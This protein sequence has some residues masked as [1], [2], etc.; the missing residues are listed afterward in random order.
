M[1]G[2]KKDKVEQPQE[3]VEDT[4]VPE[5]QHYKDME[6]RLEKTIDSRFERFEKA[7]EKFFTAASVTSPSPQKRKATKRPAPPA[8]NNH[9]TRNKALRSK[10]NPVSHTDPEVLIDN[11]DENNIQEFESPA[12]PGTSQKATRQ[13]SRRAGSRVTTDVNKDGG[14]HVPAASASLNPA[15]AKLDMNNWLLQQGTFAAAQTTRKQPM[16]A[17]DFYADDDLDAH[18]QNIIATSASAIARGNAKI[19]FFPSKYVLRGTDMK[20]AAVNTLSISEHCWAIF[21]MIHDIEVPAEIKPNLLVHIEQ[22]LED[23]QE[24]DWQT[25]VRPWSNA[26]FSRIAEGRIPGGWADR[27][28]IQNLRMISLKQARL[29][30]GIRIIPTLLGPKMQ[31]SLSTT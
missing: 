31:A 18:V 23:T 22:I 29:D 17:R 7:M 6:A 26:V 9:D 3:E 1:A 25:A 24:Y 27:T 21:R 4:L 2:K 10:Y 30:W 15:S 28:E 16:S 20:R 19:G 5:E 12:K 14:A 13:A 8:E 11:D